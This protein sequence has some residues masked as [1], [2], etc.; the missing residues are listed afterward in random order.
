M[1]EGHI[2]GL[3]RDSYYSMDGSPFENRKEMEFTL[4]NR[5]TILFSLDRKLFLFDL[6][7]TYLEG[8]K[9]DNELFSIT[10]NPG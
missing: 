5:E 6:T 1:L 9:K 3:G 10:L 7:N 2:H 8:S 4:Y